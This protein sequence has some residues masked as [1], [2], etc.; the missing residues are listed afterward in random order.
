[1]VQFYYIFVIPMVI[2]EVLSHPVENSNHVMLPASDV[3]ENELKVEPLHD[4]H[5]E[6]NEIKAVFLM[7]GNVIESNPDD[8]DTAEAVIF[9]PLFVYR[10]YTVKRRRMRF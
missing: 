1:M 7:P 8:M 6:N 5:K 9:R 10:K 4:R 2:C 3:N